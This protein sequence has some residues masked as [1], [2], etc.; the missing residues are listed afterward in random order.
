[1]DLH[2]RFSG[3]AHRARSCGPEHPRE[4]DRGVDC[5]SDYLTSTGVWLAQSSCSARWTSWTQI[6][7]SPTAEATRLTLVERASPTQ[8]TP[9]MLVSMRCGRRGRGPRPAA[10]TGP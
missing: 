3:E 10:G 5:A 1:M 7:P 2:E 9:G 4:R 8:K 6:D